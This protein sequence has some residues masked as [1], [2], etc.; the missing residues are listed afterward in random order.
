M[1]Q[2]DTPEINHGHTSRDDA[3]VLSLL[4]KSNYV[5]IENIPSLPDLSASHI[6]TNFKQSFEA[7]SENEKELQKK[8]NSV[9]EELIQLKI[10]HSET[11]KL[12]GDLKDRS[13]IDIQVLNE[14]LKKA[15]EE[16]SAAQQKSDRMDS[17]E[18]QILVSKCCEKDMEM[19]YLNEI[20][21]S[22]KQQLMKYEENV[23]KGSYNLS[24]S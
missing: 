15:N 4:K 6:T 8:L 2:Q 23:S 22:L 5:S 9:S 12:L 7:L 11:N 10:K 13:H 20:I 16:L 21:T 3:D 1:K 19:K 18:L 24:I 17:S 14:Q